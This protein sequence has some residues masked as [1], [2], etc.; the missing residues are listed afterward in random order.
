MP[1]RYCA[2]CG[3]EPALP[4]RQLGEECWLRKQGIT[5]REQWARWRLSMIA[6]ELRR[7]RVPKEE[8]PS[9]R[10]WCSGCQSFPLLLD[11]N[12]SR[13]KT[14]ASMANHSSAIL[15]KFDLS[16]DDYMRLLHRQG[17]RCGICRNRPRTRRFAVDHDHHSG[18]VRGILCDKCNHEIL[19]GAKDSLETLRNAVAY[20][21]SPPALGE[22]VMPEK[23]GPDDA[24]PPPY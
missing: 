5:V 17:G 8:W 16:S 11:C 24:G 6:P 12:G 15:G 21:E 13:C 14:C 3:V 1:L 22:W 2:D 9:G 19:G 23:K 20:L 10:R 7:D 4:R 18:E